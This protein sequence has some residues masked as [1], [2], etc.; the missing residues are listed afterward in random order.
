MDE[1]RRLAPTDLNAA[2]RVCL[3]EISLFLEREGIPAHPYAAA[4]YD[5]TFNQL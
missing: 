1:I 3:D 5:S 4:A 2:M